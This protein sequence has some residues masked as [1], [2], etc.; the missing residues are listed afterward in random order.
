MRTA[1]INGCNLC[2]ALRAERDLAN[3]V[4]RSG[5]NVAIL[6]ERDNTPPDEVFYEEVANW[7]T[8]DAF[9]ERERLAIEYADR[10]GSAPQSMDCDEDFW[11]R[12]HMH[13]SDAEIVDMTLS[14]GS[15]IA[16]GR[17][18]HVLDLDGMCTP[19]S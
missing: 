13:F 6:A 15:W 10:L 12:M 5:G 3:H 17:F 16:L 14:I 19:A 18:A 8:S 7:R 1:Q 4:E 9:S 2:L 11:Q